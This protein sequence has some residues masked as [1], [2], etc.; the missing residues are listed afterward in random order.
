MS[1]AGCSEFPAFGQIYRQQWSTVSRRSEP[2]SRTALMGEQPNPWERL[3]PQDATSRHRTFFRRYRRRRLYLHPARPMSEGSAY[4]SVWIC[5]YRHSRC[6]GPKAS[7]VTG[8]LAEASCYW[9][10]SAASRVAALPT[11]FPRYYP[12]YGAV[13]TA[14]RRWAPPLLADARPT[15]RPVHP[16]Y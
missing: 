11:D 15:F 14:P 12:S 6:L 7:V 10:R 3:H 9:S 13:R 5:R 16:R 1:S 4:C 2:S 8:S